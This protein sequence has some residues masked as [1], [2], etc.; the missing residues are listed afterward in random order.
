MEP[1]ETPREVRRLWPRVGQ[2]ECAD[3]HPLGR[4]PFRSSARRVGHH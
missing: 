2:R 4:Q 3:V 1:L